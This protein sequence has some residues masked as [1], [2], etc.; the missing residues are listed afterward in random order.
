M[1]TIQ[2]VTVTN[3]GSVVSVVYYPTS[4]HFIPRYASATG[5]SS[6]SASVIRVVYAGTDVDKTSTTADYA[7]S[8]IT[9][10][11][12]NDTWT[13]ANKGPIKDR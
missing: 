7:V 12:V 8:A 2:Q 10:L 6:C 5:I 9:T 11:V 1:A 3:T 4:I 13:N